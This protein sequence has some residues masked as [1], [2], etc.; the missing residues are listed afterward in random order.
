VWQWD[1]D[2]P[3]WGGPADRALLSADERARAGRF[4][5]PHAGRRFIAGRAAMRRTL[6]ALCGTPAASLAI[7]N[8]PNGKPHVSGGPEFN[9]SHSGSVAIFAAAEFPVGVDVE[10][11]RPIDDGVAARVF[12][13]DELA[14]LAQAVDRR[15]AFFRGWT[16]KEAVLKA[17]GGSLAELRDFSVPLRE[18]GAADP[19]WQIV[20]LAAP[21]GYAAAV[22]AARHGW[23]VVRG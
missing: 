10:A 14:E 20:D 9:L 15:S 23:S 7:G 22:A 8:G 16:R 3:E 12:T 1:L 5:A 19:S 2:A 4:L 21:P 13:A 6:A 11:L 18:S 17:R